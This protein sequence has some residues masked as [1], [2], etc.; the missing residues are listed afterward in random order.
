[1]EVK[2]GEKLY[3]VTNDP[4]SEPFAK[5]GGY[6]TR[7]PPTN[8]SE[9]VGGT[10]VMPEWNNFQRV[11]EFT[12]PPYADPIKEEPKFYAWEGPAAAQ[13]VSGDYKEKVDNG[14][15]LAGGTSQM[16]VPNKLARDK[17]YYFGKH[18]VDVTSL[19]KSW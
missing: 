3:R 4:V 5:T 16:F 18:I 11:Y 13:A 1:M 10:A 8:L 6:W 19:H 17:N 9:V 15:C 2:P 14:Y 7:T 12:A